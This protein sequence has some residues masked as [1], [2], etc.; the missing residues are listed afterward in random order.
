M[1]DVLKLIKNYLYY[2]S[3]G[4]SI[5][6]ILG[7]IAIM[8]LG[9]N[10]IDTLQKEATNQ[11]E[12]TTKVVTQVES[13]LETA[14]SEASALNKTVGEL[15]TNFRSLAFSLKS[16]GNNLKIFG[17]GVDGLDGLNILN[18]LNV[19]N[20]FQNSGNEL[21]LIG[22]NIYKIDIGKHQEGIENLKNKLNDLKNEVTHQKEIIS[23]TINTGNQIFSTLKII[24]IIFG[25]LEMIMFGIILL[26][27]IAGLGN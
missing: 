18:G 17:E 23:S 27:S 13:G 10:L 8:I 25:I 2:I 1:K 19:L 16:V 5:I 20:N 11:I 24:V 22:N 15:D 3:V 7:T 4:S 12:Q 14:V 21:I 6:G 26:N 9:Y